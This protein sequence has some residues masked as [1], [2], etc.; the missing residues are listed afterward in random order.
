MGYKRKVG[1]PT[2]TK[3]KTG[4]E[5]C[6]NLETKMGQIDLPKNKPVMVLDM[7]ILSVLEKENKKGESEDRAQ[8][9]KVDDEMGGKMSKEDEENKE[10]S[11]DG[12]EIETLVADH[13]EG[14]GEE[15]CKGVIDVFWEVAYGV[16]RINLYDIFFF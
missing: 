8:V 6:S 4:S 9:E 1:G 15:G 12:A 5:T 11:E 14:E 10:G 7:C 16:P 2:W 13:I 3:Q